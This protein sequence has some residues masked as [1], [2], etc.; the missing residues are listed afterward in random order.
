[1][2]D[3]NPKEQIYGSVAEASPKEATDEERNQTLLWNAHQ[4]LSGA[5]QPTEIMPYGYHQPPYGY[6]MYQRSPYAMPTAANQ[7]FYRP[8]PHMSYY[9]APPPPQYPYSAYPPPPPP[10]H[11]HYTQSS[12]GIPGY[13]Y[14]MAMTPPSASH[15]KVPPPFSLEKIKASMPKKYDPP[16]R[17]IDGNKIIEEGSDEVYYMGCVALGV[18]DDDYWL[19]QLQAFLRKHFAEAFTASDEDVAAPMHGRNKP[20]VLGQVGIRCRYCKGKKT[21]R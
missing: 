8:P 21:C 3:S 19:S 7:P 12:E 11:L 15:K 20:V 10:P 1:M 2:T 6:G 5:M 9:T 14:G 17:R 4:P 18:K 13:D 16:Q